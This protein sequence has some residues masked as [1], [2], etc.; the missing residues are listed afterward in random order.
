[1]ATDLGS[2]AC[3]NQVVVTERL[4]VIWPP[5]GPTHPSAGR[6]SGRGIAQSLG[7]PR[8]DPCVRG[9]VEC[10]GNFAFEDDFSWRE[11]R[12]RGTVSQG[13]VKFPAERA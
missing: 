2:H 9:V 4:R 5:F 3:E 12:P 13:S 10:A 1:M 6:S 11:I 8:S 7:A